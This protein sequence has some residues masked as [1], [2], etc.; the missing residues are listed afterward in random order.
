MQEKISLFIYLF[1]IISISCNEDRIMIEPKIVI[2]PKNILKQ[3]SKRETLI[4]T[5]KVSLN[6]SQDIFISLALNENS[7]EYSEYWFQKDFI[8]KKVNK[9][10]Y[11]YHKKWFFNIDDDP[12]LEMF[13]AIEEDVSGQ[14]GF[15]DINK[16]TLDYK[17]IFYFIPIIEKSNNSFFWGYYSNI[18]DIKIKQNSILT[19]V[20]DS[21]IRYNDFKMAKK[22]K[23][24]PLIFFKGSGSKS[25]R[26]SDRIDSLKYMT[27]SEIS[28]QIKTQ[29]K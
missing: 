16:E 10:Y 26:I 13:L 6:K 7:G 20:K 25:E 4:K 1:I 24:L 11:Q 23:K 28:S 2:T 14:Y 22:Q 18:L 17:P 9:F 12:E 8:L 21:L 5:E 3:I 15:F 27:I 19:S 29:N